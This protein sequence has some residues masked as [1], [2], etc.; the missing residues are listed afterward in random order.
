MLQGKTKPDQEKINLEV[1][2]EEWWQSRK[3]AT[4]LRKANKVRRQLEKEAMSLRERERKENKVRNLPEGN[5]KESALQNVKHIL[6]QKRKYRQKKDC[7]KGHGSNGISQVMI[8][9]PY[10]GYPY[11][12]EDINQW[13]TVHEQ[14]EIEKS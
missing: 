7:I 10:E 6:Q 11:Q 5:N 1:D 3:V 12:P 9:D 4:C 8:P 2:H 14:D 13:K